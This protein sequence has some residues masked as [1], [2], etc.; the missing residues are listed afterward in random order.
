MYLQKLVVS[1]GIDIWLFGAA[2]GYI[3]LSSSV[4]FVSK[5]KFAMFFQYLAIFCKKTF[6]VESLN[7]PVFIDLI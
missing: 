7:A 6:F 4:L 1:D 5:V 2:F 3:I